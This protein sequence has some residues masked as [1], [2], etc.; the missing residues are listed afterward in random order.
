MGKRLVGFIVLMACFCC[1][2]AAQADLPSFQGR[3]SL[4]GKVAPVP[5]NFY[6]KHLP[7]FCKKEDQLQKSTG[8]NVFF[9][10]GSKQYVDWMEGKPNAVQQ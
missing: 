4:Y 2:A 1:K 5:Q 7:F 3:F 9:R 6:T 8:L 10:L